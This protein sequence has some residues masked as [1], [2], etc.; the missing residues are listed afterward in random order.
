MS[1]PLFD[2][3]ISAH[4]WNTV[5][6]SHVIRAYEKN[7]DWAASPSRRSTSP[8]PHKGTTAYWYALAPRLEGQAGWVKLACADPRA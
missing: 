8:G 7:T 3:W 6:D 5:S 1:F 4:E 2:R